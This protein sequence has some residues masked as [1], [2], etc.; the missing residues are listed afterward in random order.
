MVSLAMIADETETLSR[1][2]ISVATPA[3]PY[4]R[5]TSRQIRQGSASK[6]PIAQANA[7]RIRRLVSRITSG[8]MFSY[9]MLSAAS[10][11]SRA[12]DMNA[13]FCRRTWVSSR[14]GP[15]NRP[16]GAMTLKIAWA[17]ALA[18][19]IIRAGGVRAGCRTLL[20]RP[21]AVGGHRPRGRD[22]LRPLRPR[23]GAAH[24]P[25]HSR[26]IP[27]SSRRT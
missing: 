17:V 21:Q 13:S 10:E 2:P 20:C 1:S 7:S 22:R 9:R 6:A 4:S 12:I 27:I 24:G 14:I 8:G 26:A 19:A 15:R 25:L 11:S 18:F 23:A 3:P 16:E 5:A